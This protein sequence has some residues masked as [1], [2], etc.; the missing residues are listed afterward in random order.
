MAALEPGMSPFMP[1]ATTAASRAGQWLA[2]RLREQG[3]IAYGSDV[4]FPD[5]GGSALI[6][7]NRCRSTGTSHEIL[8]GTPE[9]F[10]GRKAID[11]DFLDHH[12][13]EKEGPLRARRCRSERGAAGRSTSFRSWARITNSPW[14]ISRSAFFTRALSS[15]VRM[16]SRRSSVRR[17]PQNPPPGG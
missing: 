4:A 8:D 2:C 15:G 10:A 11:Q 17:M 3:L 13:G 14:R 16:S 7:R 5:A 6:S 1:T 9:G 12:E